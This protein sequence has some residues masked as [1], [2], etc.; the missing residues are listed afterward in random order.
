MLQQIM[1]LGNN[2]TSLNNVALNKDSS[3]IVS[4]K[5]ALAEKTNFEK[6]MRMLLQSIK[7]LWSNALT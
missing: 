5:T 2:T 6:M 4:G 1:F 3:K 7:Q